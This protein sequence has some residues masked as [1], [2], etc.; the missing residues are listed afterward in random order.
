M[1]DFSTETF[2]SDQNPIA[3]NWTSGPG[4]FDGMKAA[5]GV[6]GAIAKDTVAAALYS[7]GAFANDQYSQVVLASGGNDDA[8]VL[9]RFASL[10]AANGYVVA[11]SA[12]LDYIIVW[13]VTADG[14]TWTQLG[15][16]FYPAIA[17]G[18]TVKASVSGS[19]TVTI[20]VFLNGTSQGT[21]TD[22][23]SPYTSGYAGIYVYDNGTLGLNTL[24]SWVGGPSAGGG[25]LTFAATD[26]LNA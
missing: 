10:T 19:S 24:D 5:S 13:K 18:D 16:A 20:E 11:F 3:G 22:S 15:A 14:A 8:G 23:S 7:G 9:L 1:A 4:G 17:V 26:N 21:R 12:S 25:V 2:G 6:A